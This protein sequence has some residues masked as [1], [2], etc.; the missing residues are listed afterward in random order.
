MNTRSNYRAG[1]A[2]A[3]VLAL[4]LAC[5]SA[6]GAKPAA[7]SLAGEVARSQALPAAPLL[8]DEDFAR[9]SRLSQVKLA[10][11]SSALAFFE[12]DGKDNAL[13]VLDLKTSVKRKLLAIAGR[14]ELHWSSDSSTVFLDGGDT[15]STVSV[16]DGASSKIAAFDRKLEQ[17]LLAV[18]PSHPRHVLT[19]SHDRTAKAYSISRVGADGASTIIYEGDAKVHDFLVDARGQVNFIRTLDAEFGQIVARRQ[20]GKWIEHTRCKRLRACQLVSVTADGRLTMIVNQDDDRRALVQLGA[21]GKSRRILHTDPLAVSDLRNAVT[22]PSSRTPLVAVYDAPTRRNYGLTPAAARA[23]ADINKRFPDTGISISAGDG[24]AA[25]RWLLAERGPRLQQD[26]YWLYDLATRRVTPVLEDERKLGQPLPEAQL[27]S[28]IALAYRGSDGALLHGY[29]LLPPGRKA[30]EVP[31]LTMVHGGPW[32]RFDNDHSSLVQM[33]VNRGVA[34]FQPNFRAST[35]HGDKY[36]TSP[37]TDFGNGRVQ[38]DIIEGVRYLQANGVGDKNRLAIMGDS[39][40]GYAT[41]LALTHTPDMFKFGMAT[42]PPT[43]FLRTMNAAAK[44]PAYGDDAPF[45]VTLKEMGVDLNDASMVQKLVD[46]SPAANAGKVT[47]P[48]L[49]LAGGKDHIVD[50]GAVTDYVARLQGA[51]KKVSFLVDPDEGHNPRKPMVRQAYSHLLQ[52]MLHQYL[53]A[54]APAPASPELAKYLE[55]NLKLNTALD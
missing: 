41:L 8:K 45:A 18:D 2:R 23:I 1:P 30:A 15:L 53:G 47:R 13:Y 6:H 40:G 51:E 21:D 33:V 26:R 25:G 10:P 5:V 12:S 20:D 31:L 39:F 22:T 4:A 35:G 38:A 55:Q 36:M 49:I 24:T 19:E 17:Q 32:G 16:A 42:V 43:D 34:V 27:A 28:K 29:L 14:Q 37:G 7:P 3:F 11:D 48:L 44:G 9:R 54:P 46:T 52:R 50:I